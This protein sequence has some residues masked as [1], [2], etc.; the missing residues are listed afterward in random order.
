MGAT[1]IRI[2]WPG[3]SVTATLNDTVNAQAVVAV[4][5]CESEANTW[6]EE[7]YF[8]MPVSMRLEATARE[9]VEPGTV[10]FWV[11][12]SALALPYGPTPVSRGNECRLVTKVNVLGSIDGDARQ[13]A[14]IKSGD[15]IR[16]EEV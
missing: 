13:L 7:V 9:V 6:G 14:R 10:C 5:P 8:D 1:K 12:G 4:L 3:G 16:V 11:Q 15:P 2:S